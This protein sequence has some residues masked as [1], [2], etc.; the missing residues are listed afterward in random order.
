[1]SAWNFFDQMRADLKE[2]L[3]LERDSATYCAQTFMKPS[4]VTEASHAKE[5]AR[6]V[7]MVELRAQYGLN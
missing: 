5:I 7:R 3:Q 4:L 6:E 2:L 1:M